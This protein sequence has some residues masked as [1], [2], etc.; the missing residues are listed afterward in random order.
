MEII[1]PK[2]TSLNMVERRRSC[3]KNFSK[4]YNNNRTNNKYRF[5]NKMWYRKYH[6][7]SNCQA[8]QYV[9]TILPGG[10][11]LE[12]G[13]SFTT[14]IVA[15]PHFMLKLVLVNLQGERFVAT[16]NPLPTIT[17]YSCSCL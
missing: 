17:S 10:T 12:T 11:P 13:N 7:S 8:E 16:V 2:D 4:Y 3:F 6:S 15:P 1:N 5:V 14:T 9:G